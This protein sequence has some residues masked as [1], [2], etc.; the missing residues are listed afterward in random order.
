MHK[1]YIEQDGKKKQDPL[2]GDGSWR[3][4]ACNS[5]QDAQAMF[6]QLCHINCLFKISSNTVIPKCQICTGTQ[7]AKISA[8]NY[9]FMTQEH[10]TNT[11][12]KKIQP[13]KLTPY[14]RL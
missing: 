9:Q 5:Q 11:E 2:Q 7:A 10:Q 1:H 6:S 12:E 4:T 14:H 13:T 8:A 3:Q